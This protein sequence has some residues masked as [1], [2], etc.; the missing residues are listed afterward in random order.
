MREPVTKLQ[1]FRIHVT[2]RMR[3]I[4]RRYI[5]FCSKNSIWTLVPSTRPPLLRYGKKQMWMFNCSTASGR[6]SKQCFSCFCFPSRDIGVMVK[7][8][9]NMSPV[10]LH[11]SQLDHKRVRQ[12][13]THYCLFFH[14]PLTVKH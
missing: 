3:S 7:L 13:L 9:P 1:K 8:Y 10:L 4:Y 14:F 6:R 5:F 11:N 12:V 2:N